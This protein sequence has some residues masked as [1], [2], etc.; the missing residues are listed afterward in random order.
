MMGRHL[1]LGPPQTVLISCHQRHP[2]LQIAFPVRTAKVTDVE[3]QKTI[4]HILVALLA[5]MN[6]LPSSFC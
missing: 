2:P 3:Q 4:S 6:F 1:Q 5:F